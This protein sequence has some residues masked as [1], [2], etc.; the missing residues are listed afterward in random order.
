MMAVLPCACLHVPPHMP[1]FPQHSPQP[2]PVTLPATQLPT[3]CFIVILY[4]P[5]FLDF[6]FLP[7]VPPFPTHHHATVAGACRDCRCI[8]FPLRYP[9][10]HPTP[11]TPPP[12][13]Y[14]RTFVRCALLTCPAAYLRYRKPPAVARYH[15]FVPRYAAC[16]PTPTVSDSPVYLPFWWALLNGCRRGVYATIWFT[17]FSYRCRCAVGCYGAA[18]WTFACSSVLAVGHSAVHAGRVHSLNLRQPAFMPA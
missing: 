8:T 5:G 18:G 13:L 14:P 12:A 11:F 4:L 16:S 2:V 6:G 9:H 17:A 3:M 1:T 10:V 15:H 7:C